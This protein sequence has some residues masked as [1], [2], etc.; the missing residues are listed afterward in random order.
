MNDDNRKKIVK[1]QEDL[2]VEKKRADSVNKEK[3][4]VER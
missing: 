1:L 3:K 4:E 2:N